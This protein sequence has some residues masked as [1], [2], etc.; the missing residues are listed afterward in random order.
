MPKKLP[1]ETFLKTFEFAPKPAVSLLIMNSNKQILLTKRSKDPFKNYWHLPGSFLF[2]GEL[3]EECILRIAKE[4][5][6]IDLKNKKF[7]LALINE[8]INYD[9]R[10]HVLDI[11]YRIKLN[12]FFEPKPI[13]DTKEIKFFEKLPDKIGFNYREVLNKLGYK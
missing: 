8:N 12:D 6:E 1:Y 5:V 7:N 13:G 4:E 9:P 10:G 3:I 2:K 11:I